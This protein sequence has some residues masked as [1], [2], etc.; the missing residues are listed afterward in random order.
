MIYLTNAGI[1]KPHSYVICTS[2]IC[3]DTSANIKCIIHGV[4]WKSTLQQKFSSHLNV[5]QKVITVPHC[6]EESIEIAT[7]KC[8][9]LT[10]FIKTSH[11]DKSF[12]LDR[13]TDIVNRI[14]YS[15]GK[16]TLQQ[17]FSS[18][19]K[20]LQEAITSIHRFRLQHRIAEW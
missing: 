9:R 14:Y 18:H 19:L 1:S 5:F 11:L 6:S 13:E 2:K 3:K 8:Q 20:V 12:H 15:N 7:L 17:K 4:K 10:D 16:S